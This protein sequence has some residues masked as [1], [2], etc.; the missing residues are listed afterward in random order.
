MVGRATAS[1]P[2]GPWR[3]DLEPVLVPT[4]GSWDA[5]GTMRPCVLKT[6]QGYLM[7]YQARDTQ[8]GQNVF[9]LASS[10]DGINWV[11]HPEPVFRKEQVPWGAGTTLRYPYVIKEDWGWVMFFRS[12]GRMFQNSLAMAISRDGL[13]W[14]MAQDQPIFDT[15]D[16]PEWMD[17]FVLKAFHL[18]GTWYLFLELENFGSSWVHLATFKKD[19]V[20]G[21][22][23]AP[24]P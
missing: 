18:E 14:N 21:E 23:M 5:Y 4:E 16:Y 24:L 13:E 15:A 17:V 10:P 6:E 2:A 7:Y 12:S 9:G 1:N 20:P 3:V 19:L 8:F 22:N 11:K